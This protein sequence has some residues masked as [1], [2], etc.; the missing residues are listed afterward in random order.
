MFV[1]IV[2]CSYYLDELNTRIKFCLCIPNL[3]KYKHLENNRFQ[4]F[5]IE[6]PKQNHVTYAFSKL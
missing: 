1:A 3:S 6:C 4:A 5:P 2:Q